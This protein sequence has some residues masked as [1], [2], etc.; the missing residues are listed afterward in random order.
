MIL[1]NAVGRGRSGKNA[2]TS[3]LYARIA[4]HLRGDAAEQ[5]EMPA[6]VGFYVQI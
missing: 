1:K 2:E 3:I 6:I 5:L 4:V